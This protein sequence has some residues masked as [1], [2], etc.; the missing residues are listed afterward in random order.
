MPTYKLHYFNSRGR[1][2]IA[3]L[4]F[5]AAGEQF[6]DIRYEHGQWPSHKSEMPLGQ[7]PVLEVDGVKI[8]Q[9]MA[10][11]RFLAKQFHLAGGDHL[12]QAKVDAV[13]DTSIDL[14][15]KFLPILFE[16]DEDRKKTEAAKFLSEELPNHLKNFEALAHIYSDDG[17]FFV[18][19][20]LTWADLEAYDML[21]YILRLDGNVLQ[22][23]PWL[24]NNRQAVEKQPNIAA[25]LKNR[26]PM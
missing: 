3:R 4:V 1:A 13:V 9:S 19:N 18:G 14:A 26:R 8:P 7:M 23:Y 10:I 5:A 24:Q 6:E 15:L 12:A 21:D 25:Y 11:A 22:A 20:Q 2:E 17:V 16:K